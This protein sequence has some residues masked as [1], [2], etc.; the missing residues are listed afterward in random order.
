M[1]VAL[2]RHGQSAWLTAADRGAQVMF[3]VL[4]TI[5]ALKQMVV[6]PRTFPCR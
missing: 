3:R 2:T 6:F 1:L 4:G 5:V